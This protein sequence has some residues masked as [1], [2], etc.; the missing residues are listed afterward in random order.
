MK[1][2]LFI[3]SLVLIVI[4]LT[5]QDKTRSV[6]FD[7]NGTYVVYSGIPG[8]TLSG[9]QDTID[10]VF[11]YKSGGFVKKIA[12]KIRYDLISGVDTTVH[13][14]LFGREFYDDPTWVSIIA[15]TTSSVVSVNNTIQILTSDYT[16]TTAAAVDFLQQ[17]LV[18][19]K[20]TLT[21]AARINT[22]IDQSYRFYRLRLIVAGNDSVGKGIKIDEVELKFYTN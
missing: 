5:A 12:V 4:T 2:L 6:Q 11:K 13:A 20:D 16:E 17:T 14:S 8:D 21:V 1:K 10:F 18:A 7:E 19:T 22:P 15:S 9:T 3:M